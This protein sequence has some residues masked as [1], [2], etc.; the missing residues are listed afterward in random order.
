VV[1][2]RFWFTKEAI[3]DWHPEM[4]GACSRPQLYCDITIETSVFIRQVFQLPVLQTKGFM[5]SLAGIILADIIIPD[6][7]SISSS[8]AGQSFYCRFHLAQSLWQR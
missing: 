6:F 8:G 1:I 5:K 2:L 4:K 7:R 3:A